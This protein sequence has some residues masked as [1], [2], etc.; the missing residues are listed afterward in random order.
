MLQSSAEYLC[1]KRKI[2]IFV[3]MYIPASSLNVLYTAYK[4]CLYS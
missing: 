2:V 3:Y 1:G 4:M